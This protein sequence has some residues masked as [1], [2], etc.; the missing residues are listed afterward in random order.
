MNLGDRM[1]GYEN[2]HRVMLPSRFP[3][4]IRLDGRA[5]HTFTR[6]VRFEKP[7]SQSFMDGMAWTAENLCKEIMGAKFAY[8]QSDEISILLT[9][10]DT[11]ETQPWF[12]NSLQKMVSV[13]ASIATVQFNN[14]V[15]RA[16][17]FTFGAI[18][19][20][21][22]SRAF[23]IPADEVVNYFIWRQMDA[24]RN[25]L[26]G[27]CQSQ[28]SHK[29]LQG[30]RREQLHD[31]LHE[32]GINWNDLPT[33]QKRGVTVILRE[34]TWEIDREPPIFTEDRDYIESRMKK[35]K[36]KC[37]HCNSDCIDFICLSCGSM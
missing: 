29:S 27:L 26:N 19:A 13:S 35:N 22:D 18:P 14:Y 12:G 21:F 1:K 24:E 30:L 20:T 17:P 3:I 9:N 16:L 6:Q 25:S 7:F 32:K 5:F 31:K 23:V 11:I 8:I 28:F 4:I 10:D 36:P 33:Q 37:S 15:R 34:G 2:A